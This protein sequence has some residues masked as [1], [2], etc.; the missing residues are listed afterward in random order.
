MIFGNSENVSEDET[1]FGRERRRKPGTLYN[2]GQAPSKREIKSASGKQGRKQHNW[3]KQQGLTTPHGTE[4]LPPK[5]Q[6]PRTA[7][8]IPST[9]QEHKS[10]SPF[11]TRPKSPWS[12]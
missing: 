1:L 10:S 3:A 12:I 5:G 8:I 7:Y 6:T 11:P 9:P 2:R 4:K